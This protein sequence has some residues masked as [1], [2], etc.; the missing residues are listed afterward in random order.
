MPVQ[1]QSDPT[2]DL[3]RRIT[4]GLLRCA[5]AQSSLR[6]PSVGFTLIERA[7]SEEAN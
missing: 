4:A 6:R 1:V 2:L 7:K 5:L 3:S